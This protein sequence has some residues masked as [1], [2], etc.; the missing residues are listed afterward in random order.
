MVKFFVNR[1]IVAIVISVITVIVGLVMM[2]S[3]PVSQFPKIVPPEVQIL[4]TYVGAN[5]VTVEQSVATP[6]EQQISG[7]DNMNYMYSI[8]TNSG[9]MRLTVDFD[10]ATDPNVDLILT[11]IRE[12]QSEPQLPVDVRNL[13]I[14]VQKSTAAP[15][16][17]LCLYSS[18]PAFDSTF[19]AN[20]AYININDRLNRVPGIAQVQVFGAGQYA[21]RFWV[22]PDQLAKLQITVP[23]II[24]AVKAQNTVNPAGQ[25][26]GEPVPPGQE[27]T[28]SVSAQ[29]RLTTPEQFGQIVVRANT[30]GS[31]VRL[32]D[33]ARVELGA[34]LYNVRGRLD[35]QPAAVIAIYQTPGSN[36]LDAANGVKQA[37]EELRQRF[38]P[39]LNYAVGLD[40]TRAVTEGMKEILTTLLEALGLVILVVYIFLQGWRATLIPLLAVPVSLIGTFA[41]FPL[42][43]FSIN[44]LS[45]FGLV[46]A[47]GLVVDDAIVVV[48]AVE[49]KIE[50]GLAPKEATLAAMAEVASP[51]VAIALILTAVFVPTI[52][53]PGITGRMYQQFALTIAI[54]VVLSA[55]NALTLS[56]AMSALLLRPKRATR[57]PLGWFFGLFN[58]VFARGTDAYVGVS[59]VLIHK[60]IWSGLLLLAV[61]AA[62]VWVSR[63]LPRGFMPD[64]DQGY[65]YVNLQLPDAASLQRTDEVC[66]QAEKIILSTPGVRHCASVVGFSLLS[67]ANATY[68]AFFFVTLEPWSQRQAPEKQYAA[69]KARLN[70]Q[71]AGLPQGVAFCFP[72]PAIPGAGRSGGITFMLEDR[73]GK[74]IAFLDQNTKAFMAA[75]RKR[76]ELAAVSTTF[77]PAIP[78][79][80]V[81]V[82]RDK[83]LKQG[84]AL[85]DVYQTLQTFM[86]GFFINYFNDFGR[87]WQVYVE[88]EGQYRARAEDIGQFYVRNDRG[89]MVPLSALLRIERTT[90]PEF[91]M[92][93]NLYR[94]AQ[95]NAQA[96][97][98]YSSAQGMA[99][100]E[101]V[102]AQTMPREMGF[103]YLGMS[104]QEQQVQQGIPPAVVYVLSLVFVFLILAA[105]YESWSLPFS[106][107]MVTPVA[108]LGALGVLLLRRLGSDVFENNVYAQIGIV[109]LIGLSAKN[110]ILIV[111][112]AKAELK[113]KPILDAALAGGRIRLRPILMTSFAMIFGLLPLWF[114]SGAG[115]LARQILGTAVI[116]G[117]LAATLIAVFLIP[118]AF[119]AV[120]SI[121]H[122][123][124]RKPPPA[125]TTP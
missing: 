84:V 19:L 105:Q 77:L 111:A 81:D 25:V 60:G 50:Q 35:S 59:R 24:N 33:V 28:Y 78:Q 3:L 83:V 7:V 87:Q 29:G 57:G 91:T 99:A 9:Q 21:M 82:D 17:L 121:A 68:S 98:G 34:Q 103:D 89:Q 90:G 86:G 18:N 93:Y 26:G 74:D 11:Q 40:T 43:G 79:L 30:D 38:P 41:V 61:T 65:V 6:M 95:I 54:S 119:Y 112:F 69:I 14:T 118:F 58:R 104:F 1:P 52:F 72:P 85:P 23:E 125:A 114:A 123:V 113:G 94:S 110:A 63:E 27:L 67:V 8:N 108:V 37:M 46:L 56:P 20:Y 88:A 51:I 107:L 66:R 101:Q 76:P 4:A 49:R 117:F 102:F 15:L 75:A 92:R 39:G 122:H 80:F 96:A 22:N 12:S 100:L 42:F 32:K 106:V 120:E 45:L 71:L 62:A 109:M 48:E 16:L 31:V 70:A 53:L 97:P 115:A 36:A 13:G 116:G 73:S 124:R 2:L 47:I 10:V 5:A 44:T 55:F 64:E